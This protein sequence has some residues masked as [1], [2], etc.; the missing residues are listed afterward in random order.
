MIHLPLFIYISMKILAVEVGQRRCTKL[1][2]FLKIIIITTGSFL[3]SNIIPL[4]FSYFHSG[5]L[6]IKKELLNFNDLQNMEQV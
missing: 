6:V 1:N 4:N 3:R 5:I 2:Q